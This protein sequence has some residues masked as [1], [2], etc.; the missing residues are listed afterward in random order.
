MS[1]DSSLYQISHTLAYSVKLLSGSLS[2]QNPGNQFG[3]AAPIFTIILLCITAV[4]QIICLNRGLR[5][6]DSTLVVPMFYGIYT[7]TGY[8]SYFEN[9]TLDTCTQMGLS[10]LGRFLDSLIFN[11]EVDSYKSWTLFLIFVSML[12]LISGVV[13]LTHKKS[14]QAPIPSGSA[15][16]VPILRSGRNRR[17]EDD[18]EALGLDEHGEGKETEDGE[19]DS[20]VLWTV[21]EESDEEGGT[22]HQLVRP[23]RSKSNGGSR[24]GRG[25]GEERIGLIGPRERIE[26]AGRSASSDAA[27]LRGDDHDLLRDEFGEWEDAGI[28]S[29]DA[30]LL[31]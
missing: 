24:M 17:T 28:G 4:L 14:E 2:H 9:R 1:E 6:Y 5:V 23:R 7:A 13:L 11:D 31:R 10:M 18:E 8:V 3:H 22:S 15:S 25:L 12:I 29:T 21:G 19:S 27:L 26:E 20:S 30:K 16:A